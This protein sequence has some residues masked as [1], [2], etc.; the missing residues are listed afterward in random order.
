MGDLEA[1]FEVIF[2]LR[3]RALLSTAKLLICEMS[4]RPLGRSLQRGL[5]DQQALNTYFIKGLLLG[6]TAQLY[7][8][9]LGRPTLP[10]AF[11][12]RRGG[13]LAPPRWEEALRCFH[14]DMV[15]KNSSR[16]PSP[17]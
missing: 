11:G 7:F 17:P 10:L 15:L 9:G 6:L 12:S 13:R 3:S 14:E 4:L 1:I 8:K 5:E 16:T 2:S